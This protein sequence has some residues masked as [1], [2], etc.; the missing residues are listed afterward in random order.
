MQIKYNY[1]LISQE[2]LYIKQTNKEKQ[3]RRNFSSAYSDGGH[4]TGCNG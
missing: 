1:C 2:E 3:K 4:L